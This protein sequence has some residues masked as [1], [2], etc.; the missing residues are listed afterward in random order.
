MN[1]NNFKFKSKNLFVS[2]LIGV[3]FFKIA[4]QNNILKSHE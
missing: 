4:K 2:T 1:F 3:S